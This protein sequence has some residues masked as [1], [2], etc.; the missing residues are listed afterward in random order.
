VNWRTQ[1]FDRAIARAI[2]NGFDDEDFAGWGEIDGQTRIAA[3]NQILH[4]NG[5]GQ[6]I[7]RKSFARAFYGLHKQAENPDSITH[8]CVNC[9]LPLMAAGDLVDGS[10]RQCFDVHRQR[11][12][13]A[14]DWL[15]YLREYMNGR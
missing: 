12:V 10:G 1:T 9:D 11:C 3:I 13:I 8:K 15:A 14:D 7:F 6:I 5:V 4:H 2:N